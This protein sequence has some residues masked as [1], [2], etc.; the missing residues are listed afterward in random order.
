LLSSFC[1]VILTRGCGYECIL[2][3]S[4][5]IVDPFSVMIKHACDRVSAFPAFANDV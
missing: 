1:F 5:Y 4:R 2:I 3:W